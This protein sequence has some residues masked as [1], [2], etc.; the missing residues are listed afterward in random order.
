MNTAA[1]TRTLAERPADRS[2]PLLCALTGIALLVALT[3]ISTRVG[4]V[5]PDS[6]SYLMMADSLLEKGSCEIGGKYSAIHPCGYPAMIAVVAWIGQIE[7]FLAGKL[8]NLAMLAGTG[9]LAWRATRNPLFGFLFIANPVVLSLGHYLWSENAFILSVALVFYGIVR[10]SERQGHA[11]DHVAI[12]AGLVIGVTTR[13]YFAPYAFLIFLA[14]WAVY[15]SRL[16][17]RVLP[18]FVVSA[19]LF[20]GYLFFNHQVSGEI[21][22]MPRI[23]APES[24]G[25]LSSR[26]AG[27][28]WQESQRYTLAYVPL[29][30]ALALPLL[31]RTT[32]PSSVPDGRP[33]R[34]MMLLGGAYLVL[35]FAMRLYTQYDLY[36][37]R[38]VGY[39]FS[40]LI[41]AVLAS[42]LRLPAAR[43]AGLAALSL[44]AAAS[45]F[46][47]QK[48]LYTGLLG[49]HADAYL[50]KT[51]SEAMNAYR[52]PEEIRAAD[53]VVPFNL[54][55]PKW[56]V[57]PNSH[58]YYGRNTKSIYI[59][60]A[61]YSV[62]ETHDEL[63]T[64]LQEYGSGCFLD[65]T[66][67]NSR[68]D[69]DYILNITFPIGSQESGAR[70]FD[71]AYDQ[72]LAERLREV[73]VPN[74]AVPCSMF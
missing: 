58:Y 73:F 32:V 27:Y 41:S 25:F 71:F 74:A 49:P 16:A 13:Y 45:L 34:L 5:S 15:G 28:L 50:G 51:F 56:S 4:F 60:A 59:E 38:T 33:Y 43:T 48:E 72:K 67:V 14:V 8:L 35:A 57:A 46:L 53:A 66:H 65:F 55:S 26:F 62:R 39:G 11:L 63:K 54:P 42:R 23:P 19:F 44:T 22:G 9:G 17:L 31:F 2:V 20:L 21:T 30:A 52:A 1:P 3:A 64:R 37:E 70:D 47:S 6:W 10:L 36:G 69:M 18:W 61:P 24:L 29:L 40:F 12:L 68:K 7:P